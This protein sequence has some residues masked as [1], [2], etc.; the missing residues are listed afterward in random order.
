MTEVVRGQVSDRPW[1]Q[2][3]AQLGIRKVTGQLTV[4][5]ANGRAYE[6]ALALGRVVG[7]RSPQSADSAPRIALTEGLVTSSQ[8][9][10]LAERI[11]ASPD[12]DEAQTIATACRLD[13]TQAL[14]LRRRL[15]VQRAARTFSIEDGAFV[16]DDVLTIPVTNDVPVDLHEVIHQGARTNLAEHRLARDLRGFGS[17]FALAAEADQ[18]TERFGFDAAA[19]A[20]LD[21][22]RDAKT[23]AELEALHR[24]LE[25]RWVHSVVYALVSCRACVPTATLPAARTT[26]PPLLART[27]TPPAAARTSTPRPRAITPPIA[28]PGDDDDYKLALRTTE[29]P[30]EPRL[31]TRPIRPTA[32]APQPPRT[33]SSSAPPVSRPIVPPRTASHSIAPA[34]RIYTDEV[35]VAR[36]ASGTHPVTRVPTVPPT[37]APMV[38]ITKPPAPTPPRTTT[39]PLE[40]K[41]DPAVAAANA[42]REGQVALSS[43]DL[44]RTVERF[45]KAM[46]LNPREFA[47]SASLAWAQFLL[48]PDAER[49][50]SASKVRNLLTHAIQKSVE[51][52]SL[53]LYLGWLD[54]TLGN[55]KQA[56]QHF[57]SIREGES[58]YAEAQQALEE[59]G[60]SGLVP[61]P[62]GLGLFR[63]KP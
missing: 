30:S 56:V 6:V 5:V 62:L 24:D 60:Q 15:I 41:L 37:T 28:L 63:K 42:Y 17:Y 12:K 14:R 27:P 34:P 40:P 36:G 29:I 32:P 16:V 8:T 21:S 59:I 18:H 57:S 50:K 39:P 31:V 26:T 45:T 46:V 4:R 1:G 11:A 10:L 48:A 33:P 52:A 55:D 13:V 2:T 20:V 7:A 51:S 3:L 22:L 49:A 35:G 25:P 23:L 44:E 9:A 53:R 19:R 43:D 54:R 47:Y 58:G 61:K 38:S